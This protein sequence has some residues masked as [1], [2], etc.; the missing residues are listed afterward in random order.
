MLGCDY[1]ITDGFD[2]VSPGRS[3]VDLPDRLARFA[4]S[5]ATKGGAW[6]DLVPGKTWVI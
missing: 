1:V 3:E 6:K 2:D 5:G 4:Y